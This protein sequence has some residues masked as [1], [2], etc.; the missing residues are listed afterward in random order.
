MTKKSQKPLMIF[1]AER[2]GSTIFFSIISEYLRQTQ[3]VTG[4]VEFFNQTLCIDEKDG[5]ITSRFQERPIEGFFKTEISRRLN[6]LSE[7]P[8]RYFFKVMSSQIYRKDQYRWLAANYDWVFVERR[9]LF[10]QYLSYLISIETNIFYA[11][12][13]VRLPER[14]IRGG[15]RFRKAFM[16]SFWLYKIAKIHCRPSRV[17]VYEDYLE[18]PSP[19]EIL[20][21]LG[22][23][24]ESFDEKLVR[25]PSQ[26]NEGDKLRFFIHPKSI[27]RSYKRSFLNQIRP[28]ELD[29][30]FSRTDVSSGN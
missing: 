8:G 3:G 30:A 13:G 25:L 29:N 10:E 22:L 2:S 16:N 6:I 23:P 12:D 26:Q 18:R 27:I 4:V 28:F 7:N 14:S 19:T 9:N 11:K 1:A 21:S 24:T 17:L 20:Q 5:Q 15:V